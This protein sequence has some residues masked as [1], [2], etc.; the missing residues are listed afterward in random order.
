MPAEHT[1]EFDPANNVC[2]VCRYQRVPGESVVSFG[3]GRSQ[4]QQ[5]K[6]GDRILGKAP[7]EVTRINL[8]TED[9]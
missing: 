3:G 2:R 9:K 8:E 4:E 6:D 7:G 1:H 5:R